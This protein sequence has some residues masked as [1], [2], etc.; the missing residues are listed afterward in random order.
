MRLLNTYLVAL[1]SNYLIIEAHFQQSSR[2][3]MS[4]PHQVRSTSLLAS[5]FVNG[6]YIPSGLLLAGVGIVKPQWLP[7][8]IAISL[9]LGAWRI[10]S[11]GRHS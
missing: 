1:S 8:A 2:L 11:A 7:Y 9:V 4:A 10:Y 3:Q 5:Q 6:V